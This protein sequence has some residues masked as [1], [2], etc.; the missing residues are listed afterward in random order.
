L[1]FE[2]LRCVLILACP[3]LLSMPTSF[4]AVLFP[5]TLAGKQTEHAAWGSSKPFLSERRLWDLH[6]LLIVPAAI[7]LELTATC[8]ANRPMMMLLAPIRW[9]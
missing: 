1:T 9:R 8:D 2:F 7:S 4:A 5:A 3:A 6:K